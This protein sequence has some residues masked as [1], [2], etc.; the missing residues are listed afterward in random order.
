VQVLLGVRAL[1]PLALGLLALVV[2]AWALLVQVLLASLAAW[3]QAGVGGLVACLFP[4]NFIYP[5]DVFG[6]SLPSILRWSRNG[7]NL[8]VRPGAGLGPYT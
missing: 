4:P 7:S 3:A 6:E 8:S 2:L 5:N 1:E